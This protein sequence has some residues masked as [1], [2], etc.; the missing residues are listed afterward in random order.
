MSI[1]GKLY[2]I[3]ESQKAVVFWYNKNLLATA[4]STTAELKS[5]MES[6]VPIGISFG[7]YHHFGFFGAFGGE[8][9]N[10]NG[11]LIADQGDGVT[12]AMNYLNG[13][14]QISKSN[15][16]PRSDVEVLTPFIEGRIAGLTN[17]N[18]AMGDYKN[19]LG[20]NLGVAPLPSGPGGPA[21]PMLGIDGFYINPNSK[22]KEIAIEVALYLTNKQSQT[23]MMNEAGHVPVNM[24][25]DITDPLIQGLIA[26]FQNGYVRPQSPQISKYWNNFCDTDQVFEYNVSAENWVKEA[27]ANANK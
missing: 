10:N 14:Y 26:A 15:N 20:D 9:F 11:N 18:W 21:Q 23:I 4:P 22:N 8:I 24:T 6:G 17:G 1:N 7:C 27:T 13:L 3:P 16:W 19:A 25:V 5:I 12:N 2:G